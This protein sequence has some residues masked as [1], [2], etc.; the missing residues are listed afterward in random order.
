MYST[1]LS[2]FQDDETGEYGLAHANAINDPCGENFNALWDGEGIFHDVFEHYFEGIHR[3]FTGQYA[4][5]IAGEVAAMGHMAYYVYGMG[6]YQRKGNTY[7][8]KGQLMNMVDST[9]YMMEEAISEGN[10]RFG[11]SFQVA[12]PRQKSVD[13]HSIEQMI[14]A[15]WEQIKATRPGSQVEG[16][17]CLLDCV[18][19]R[20][21]VSKSKLMRLYRWGH[22][23]AERIAPNTHQNVATLDG[24]IRFWSSFTNQVDAGECYRQ[25]YTGVTVRVYPGQNLRWSAVFHHP[26]RPDIREKTLLNRFS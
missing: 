10:F 14:G 4:F 1:K 23:Q 11:D 15:H 6:L 2:L 9:C 17:D 16:P 12:L 13:S 8:Q 24:F 20:Q 7:Y 21:S 25:G 26:Q 22:K 3:H 19:Y 5:N 18:R